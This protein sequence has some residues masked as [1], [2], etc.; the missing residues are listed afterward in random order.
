MNARNRAVAGWL[1]VGAIGFVAVPWYM[2]EASLLSSAWLT[3]FNDA[4]NAPAL[5]QAAKHGRTWLWPVGALLLAGCALLTP[6]LDRNLRARAL[7]VLGAAG[8]LYTFAQGFAIGAQGWSFDALTRAWGPLSGK[9]YGMGLGAALALCAFSMLFA[10][11]LAERGNFGGDGFIAG[12]IVAILAATTVFTFF[13]ILNILISAFQDDTG[14]FRLKMPDAKADKYRP[15]RGKQVV[16]GIR[17]EDV[18]DPHFAPPG[19]HSGLVDSMV[20]VTELM[21]NEVI[22]Y[23]NTQ[24]KPFLARVDPRTKSRVGSKVQVAMNMDNLHIFDKQTEKA[25]R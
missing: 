1:A 16:F 23:L 19:I 18:H 14:A 9:Q 21:G 25:V 24:D 8:F 4:T 10:L 3:N 7:M 13:P 20:E 2:L 5:L 12:S 22:V 11:G 6:G 15:L 17:P